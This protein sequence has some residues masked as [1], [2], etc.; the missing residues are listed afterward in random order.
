MAN[1]R[2]LS[3]PTP[4]QFDFDREKFK[5]LVVYVA[6]KSQDDPTFGAVKL[7]KILYYADFSAYRDLG[8]PITGAIYRK[9]TEG[10][11][12]RDMVAIRDELI[13]ERRLRHEERPYFTRIQKR[14]VPTE[15]TEADTE[16]LSPKEREL[17][18][19]ILLFFHGKTAREVSDYS[20]R[21]PGWIAAQLRE[22]IPYQTA[23][24]SGTPV[25]QEE[26]EAAVEIARDYLS[27]RK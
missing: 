22:E 14:L 11:A 16:F 12:P 15:G 13:T 21:E 20:H 3:T 9:L 19:R 2:Y 4:K 27:Q 6:A 1:K 26:E 25:S 5:D 10:P 23:F 24:L 8:K 17:I 18:D 7:N